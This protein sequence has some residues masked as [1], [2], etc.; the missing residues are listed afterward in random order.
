YD[1]IS[2]NF[3]LN[4]IT[5]N[6]IDYTTEATD[7]SGAPMRVHI[8]AQY[9]ASTQTLDG[10][11]D[12]YFYNNPG[13]QRK[14]GFSVSL[15]T[16]DSGYVDCSKVVDNGGCYAAIRIYKQSS[17]AATAKRYNKS[18][19]EDDCNIGIFNKYYKK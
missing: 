16:D 1:V 19:Y 9:N 8:T 7:Y 6:V 10:I 5:G 3:S 17:R 15:A 11:F 14:D 2:F 4:N 12:F 18:L 13:Q